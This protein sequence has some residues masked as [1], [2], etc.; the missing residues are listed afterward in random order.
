MR[1]QPLFAD[2][3]AQM[4]RE[5]ELEEMGVASDEMRLE[6]G[7]RRLAG[8]LGEMGRGAPVLLRLTDGSR[9]A[10]LVEAVGEDW[11]AGRQRDTGRAALIPVSAVVTATAPAERLAEARGERAETTSLRFGVV[12]RDLARRRCAVSV[13]TTVG[14]MSGTIDGVGGDHLEL[15]VHPADTVRRQREVI[16]IELLPLTA[17]VRIDY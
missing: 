3:E 11:V 17:I 2:L 1:W 9:V 15:A 4:S 13:S 5:L 16:A 12:L 8:R 10:L 14:R 7:R 6:R